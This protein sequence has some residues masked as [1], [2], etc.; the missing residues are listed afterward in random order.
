VKI[1]LQDSL[2]RDHVQVLI[3]QVCCL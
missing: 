3:F 2:H 1:C